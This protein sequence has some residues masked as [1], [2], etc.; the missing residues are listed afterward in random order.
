M[1]RRWL[2]CGVKSVRLKSRKG[3]KGEETGRELGKVIEVEEKKEEG[4]TRKEKRE[5]KSAAGER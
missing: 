2:K 1:R 3:I 4:R 5:M